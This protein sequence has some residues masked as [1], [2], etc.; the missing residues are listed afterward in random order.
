MPF[1][2][3]LM[4]TYQENPRDKGT[5]YDDQSSWDALGIPE[6]IASILME[7]PDV[8]E[9]NLELTKFMAVILSSVEQ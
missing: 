6:V 1:L 5:E 2:R 9:L 3:D 8:S 4:S 7:W